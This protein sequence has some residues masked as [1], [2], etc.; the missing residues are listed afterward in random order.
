MSTESPVANNKEVEEESLFSFYENDNGSLYCQIN[1]SIEFDEKMKQQYL[2][3]NSDL[4]S[5]KLKHDTQIPEMFKRNSAIEQI[6]YLNHALYP[7][8]SNVSELI[9]NVSELIGHETFDC[10][11]SC[12]LEISGRR[13][14]RYHIQS[15]I[16]ALDRMNLE[17][18]QLKTVKSFT[19]WALLEPKRS[20]C[21]RRQKNPYWLPGYTGNHM[22]TINENSANISCGFRHEANLFTTACKSHCI[23]SGELNR[24]QKGK[25]T[26]QARKLL[27]CQPSEG[28]STDSDFFNT[29]IVQGLTFS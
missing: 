9:G 11:K 26:S 29:S 24:K 28:Y 25:A 5:L 6:L 21:M 13:V 27:R 3:A 2:N 19:R 14:Q 18:N 7:L 22:G 15:I 16:E 12:Y 23:H 1:K 4:R 17:D 10:I 8:D 20:C